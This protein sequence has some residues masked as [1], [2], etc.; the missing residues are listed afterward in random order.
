MEDE[1]LKDAIYNCF[2]TDYG[3]ERMNI[4]DG[5]FAIADA[6]NALEK[7]VGSEPTIDMNKRLC[8]ALQSMGSS[9]GDGG[10][11]I[12]NSLDRVAEAIKEHGKRTGNEPE[13]KPDI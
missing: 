4:V 6:I 1:A 7:T 5:L 12:S 13:I 11:E 9:S 10:L 8:E 2:M 3:Q